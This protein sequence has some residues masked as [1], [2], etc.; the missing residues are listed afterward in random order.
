VAL[1]DLLRSLFFLRGGGD[2]LF[3]L[4][5]ALFFLLH[6]AGFSLL[7]VLVLLFGFR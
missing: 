7:L 4:D 2:D 5:D 1:S 3:T 6:G